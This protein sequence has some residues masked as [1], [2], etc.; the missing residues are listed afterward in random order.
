MFDSFLQES[1][2]CC[3]QFASPAH[4]DAEQRTEQEP[5]DDVEVEEEEAP[6]A[7]R[8]PL[9]VPYKGDE[10]KAMGPHLEKQAEEESEFLD[11]LQMCGIPKMRL[12]DAKLGSPYLASLGQPS[13]DFTT[14]TDTSQ[15]R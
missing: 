13:E 6:A 4:M 3:C 7:D 1:E 5:I 12:H 15:S 2:L 14:S 9:D 10:A 11:S 8:T